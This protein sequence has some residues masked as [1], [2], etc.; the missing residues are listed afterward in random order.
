MQH[1]KTRLG[2]LLKQLTR[3]YSTAGPKVIFEKKTPQ[4]RFVTLNVPKTLNSLDFDMINMIQNQYF[5]WQ[6]DEEAQIVCFKGEGKAFCAG[7]DIMKLYSAKKQATEGKKPAIH[8]TFFRNEFTLDYSLATMRPTQVAIWDGFVMGGGVGLSIHAP[9]KI[10]TENSVFAMPEAKIGFFTDVG[11]G[12]FLSKLPNHVGRYLAFTSDVL[13][14][15]DLV[16]AGVATHY[17]PSE[18]L[19]QFEQQ[20]ADEVNN[21]NSDEIL[22]SLLEKYTTPVEGELANIEKI[23]E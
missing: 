1:S 17:M 13:K 18:N 6:E 9:V 5:I 22:N 15:E 16:K 10:A 12:Y 19:Q 14:G 4:V 20:L 23:S 11:G 3:A 7:G 8:D 21:D 2:R